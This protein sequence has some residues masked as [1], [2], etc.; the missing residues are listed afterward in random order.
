MSCLTGLILDSK[1]VSAEKKNKVVLAF[2]P[3]VLTLICSSPH[4]THLSR[5]GCADYDLLF[6]QA[7]FS[8]RLHE[9]AVQKV[10]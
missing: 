2:S 10:Y 4:S 9:K 3:V 8:R 7:D 6:L 5:G 1:T